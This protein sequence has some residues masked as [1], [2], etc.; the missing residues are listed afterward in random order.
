M[1]SPDT[2]ILVVD[3][4]R[5]MRK[6]VQKS[7]TDLG[8]KNYL[9]AGDGAE[10]WQ[11][12]ND[13]AGKVG[14][15]ISDWNMPNCTGLDFLKRVRADSRFKKLPF[16]ML[17]AESEKTQIMAAIQ[18]GVDTYVI[19]PFTPAILQQKLTQ[20]WTKVSAAAA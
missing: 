18:A 13:N 17:T 20:V 7:C 3:D 2:L 11:V 12:L 16:V 14:L 5:T 1:F 9:E 19:K 8:F 10:A 4:M 6:V 15:V